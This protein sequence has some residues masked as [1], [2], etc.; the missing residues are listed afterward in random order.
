MRRLG[1][2]LLAPILSSA[3][4]AQES[5]SFRVT[6]SVWNAG[7]HPHDGAVLA[8]SSFS[9]TLDGIG[10]SAP[11][12]SMRSASFGV[13]LGFVGQFP[14]PREVVGLDFIDEESLT[15]VP[16]R[17][18]GTYNVYRDDLG[19]LPAGGYGACWQAR[20]VAPA[21][22]DPEAPASG[23]G[24]FYLVTAENRLGEEST[25]GCASDGTERPNT[26]PCP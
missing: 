10:E 22:F 8:S 9:V 11:P 17:S 7:G 21:A 20:L 14:P 2:F 4:I 6:E 1:L 19:A 5:A 26:A 23:Q 25:K 16:E 18:A 13:M 15:W 3:V 24:A 12:T